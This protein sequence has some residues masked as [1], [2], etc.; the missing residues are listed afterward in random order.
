MASTTTEIRTRKENAMFK[1][2]KIGLV[3]GLLSVSMVAMLGTEANADH[4]VCTC[5]DGSGCCFYAPHSI[6]CHLTA[7]GAQ[8]N[9]TLKCTLEASGEEGYTAIVICQNRGKTAAGGVNTIEFPLASASQ[10][11][12]VSDINNGIATADVVINVESTAAANAICANN[13]NRNWTAKLVIICNP[14][15]TA[16]FSRLSTEIEGQTS[17]CI[18]PV[19][20]CSREPGEFTEVLDINIK[21]GTIAPEDLDIL[22]VDASDTSRLCGQ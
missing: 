20:Q 8:P 15:L 14:T 22:Y 17:Q 21:T 3:I 16:G 7:A 11:V 10:D 4:R 18:L 5:A 13:L 2:V 1:R 9:D 19:S 6:G 12:T